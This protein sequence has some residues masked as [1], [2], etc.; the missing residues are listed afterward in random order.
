MKFEK[1][2]NNLESLSYNEKQ[3]LIKDIKQEYNITLGYVDKLNRVIECKS[4]QDLKVNLS[5]GSQFN[6][7]IK[8]VIQ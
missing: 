5:I 3:Q 2:L 1:Q 7:G 8:L 6:M 4:I